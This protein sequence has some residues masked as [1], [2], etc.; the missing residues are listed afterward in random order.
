M[1]DLAILG[2]IINIII[3]LISFFINHYLI[4]G[5]VLACLL[6]MLICLLNKKL[7]KYTFCLFIGIIFSIYL[8]LYFENGLQFLIY[9]IFLIISAIYSYYYLLDKEHNRGNLTLKIISVPINQDYLVIK[10]IKGLNC[11]TGNGMIIKK[12][13]G[14]QILIEN[15]N[16]VK[17]FT[18]L[19]SDIAKIEILNK[20]Y[21]YQKESLKNHELDI[22]K[23]YMTGTP[24]SDPDSTVYGNAIKFKKAFFIHIFL[25]NEEEIVLLSF[26]D[27]H[28][29]FNLK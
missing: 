8:L 22:T 3:I 13:K 23:S 19:A 7:V 9:I 10:H 20:P 16:E 28:Q 21:I 12:E 2:I 11:K 1:K 18:I 24:S 4:Y 6:G 27:P 14:Y 26:N 15:Q 29:F 5:I 25:F 17:E